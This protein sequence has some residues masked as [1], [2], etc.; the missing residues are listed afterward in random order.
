MHHPLSRRGARGRRLIMLHVR[1]HETMHVH[2][3]TTARYGSGHSIG[4][5]DWGRPEQGGG[6]R[7]V[8]DATEEALAVV[9]VRTWLISGRARD[10]RK[11]AGLSQADVGRAIG[12]DGPQISRWES[13]KAVPYFDSALRLARLL[14]GLEEIMRDGQDAA[15]EATATT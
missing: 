11:R 12:T 9:R 13:G 5:M 14:D 4:A 7:P 1:M 8:M 2:A 10:I 6:K 15:D 3:Q